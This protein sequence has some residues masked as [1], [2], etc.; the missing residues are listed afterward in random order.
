MTALR[1]IVNGKVAQRDDFR[2]AVSVCRGA[3]HRVDVRVTWEPGD[4]AR[5]VGEALASLAEQPID[6]LVAAGG[7]GTLNE[8]VAAGHQAGALDRL[9]FAVLP[10][11]TANDFARSVG[12]DPEDPVAGLERIAAAKPI[13]ID[14][15]QA[16]GVPFVN[17]ATCGMG[18]DLEPGA[19][20]ILKRL[21]GPAAYILTGLAR[22]A[23]LTPLR[24]RL[25]GP[26]FTWAGEFIGLAVGNGIQAGGGFV[27]CPDAKIDDGLLDVAI[28]PEMTFEFL[29]ALLTDLSE[30]GLDAWRRRLVRVR[31]ASLHVETEATV[32]F[33]LD[34]QPHRDRRF[35][36]SV[37]ARTVPFVL[38][39][40][41]RTLLAN[42]P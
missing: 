31:L 4:A 29:S 1:L 35:N 28:L 23:D 40:T 27:L 5:F 42:A 17:V 16:N 6:V 33:S 24:G 20:P 8:V 30:D 25:H 14:L 2:R 32:T 37:E 34:G 21:A 10:L 7:D 9:T 15:G 19:D 22:A 11:G 39:P 3:G 36:F 41:A 18:S 38:G 12:F 26:G 13:P